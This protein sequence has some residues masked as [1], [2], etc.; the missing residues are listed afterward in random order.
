M[1]ACVESIW[2]FFNFI[3]HTILKF[4]LHS[5]NDDAFDSEFTSAKIRNKRL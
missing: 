5:R 4:Y 3:T 2:I 1:D